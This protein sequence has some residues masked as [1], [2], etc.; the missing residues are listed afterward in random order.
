MG[1]SAKVMRTIYADQMRT[2]EMQL[3]PDL[4]EPEARTPIEA[5]SS[6]E[7]LRSVYSDPGQPITR[8]LRAAIAALPFEHPKLAVVA[9]MHANE[10]FAAQLEAAIARSRNVIEVSASNKDSLGRS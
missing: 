2:R 1:L 10:G 9:S 7:L 3:L 4:S 8:R 5:T 6:L